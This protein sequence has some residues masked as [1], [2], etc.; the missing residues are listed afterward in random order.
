MAVNYRIRVRRLM[1]TAQSFTDQGNTALAQEYAEKAAELATKHGVEDALNEAF[2]EQPGKVI[3]KKVTVSNPYPKHR[4]TLISVIGKHFGCKVIKSGRNGAEIFGDERDVERVM[5]LYRLIS[6][7]MLDGVAK[8]RPELP[9]R[10]GQ[11]HWYFKTEGLTPA[12]TKSFRVSWVI[13]YISG[14][15]SRMAEAYRVTVEEAKVSNPGAALVL[16]DRKAVAERLMRETYPNLR[17]GAASAVKNAEGFYAGRAASGNADLG[18][19]R[20][21]PVSRALTA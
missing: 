1:E 3:L 4:I 13:G 8:A 12:E 18:Q 14:I 15:D 19:E 2:S 11:K 16:A 6:A 7:H 21:A 9:Q 20:I 17:K 10:E 5:F